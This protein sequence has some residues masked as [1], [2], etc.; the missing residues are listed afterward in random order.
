MAESLVSLLSSAFNWSH[1]TTQA[2]FEA[3]LGHM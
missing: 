1:L 2:G 3:G